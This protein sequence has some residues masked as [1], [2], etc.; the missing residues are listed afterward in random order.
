MPETKLTKA[1]IHSAI[2]RGELDF[3]VDSI[4]CKIIEVPK[5]LVGFE[6]GDTILHIAARYGQVKVLAH[7]AEFIDSSI[8]NTGGIIA[9]KVAASYG[10]HAKKGPAKNSVGLS[11]SFKD[12]DEA[13]KAYKNQ[14]SRGRGI[15]GTSIFSELSDVAEE[16]SSVRKV[17]WQSEEDPRPDMARIFN[18]AKMPAGKDRDAEFANLK[19][20]ISDK[21]LPS[22]GENLNIS[23]GTSGVYTSLIGPDGKNLDS[24][25]LYLEV[26]QRIAEERK[27]INE[28]KSEKDA[29]KNGFLFKAAQGTLTKEDVVNYLEG[30]RDGKKAG[31]KDEYYTFGGGGLT[32]A[33]SRKDETGLKDAEHAGSNALHHAIK[34]GHIETAKML[35]EGVEVKG[36][37]FAIDFDEKARDILTKCL[38]EKPSDPEYQKFKTYLEGPV[39]T[40]KLKPPEPSPTHPQVPALNLGAV[41]AKEA[42]V[43]GRGP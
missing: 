20:S 27:K 38:K 14:L 41:V 42:A 39:I 33:T 32:D 34:N 3:L 29:V 26:S 31:E 1:E 2:R 21:V 23:S 16:D 18:I 36:E 19:K 28:E 12:R 43:G 8:K 4:A 37:I 35:L 13:V 10:N 11:V 15:F 6:G 9:E 25:A 5:D 22:R 7:F 24:A 17:L 40:T 30:R